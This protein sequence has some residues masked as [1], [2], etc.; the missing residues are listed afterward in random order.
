M[1]FLP[2]ASANEG[3]SNGVDERVRR[4][5][6]HVFELL[7]FRPVI[8]NSHCASRNSKTYPVPVA[9]RSRLSEPNTISRRQALGG[10][11]ALGGLG[12]LR[13]WGRPL[14]ASDKADIAFI[15]IGGYGA[16]NMVGLAGDNIVAVCDVDWRD[17]DQLPGRFTRASEVAMQYPGAKR[18]D[19]WRVM[20]D[21][22]EKQIDAV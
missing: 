9:G 18:F 2:S 16:Q 10:A 4:L 5:D 6:G 8:C 20:L 12:A 19:D 1:L 3:T 11:A 15:G 22:M 7:P 17:K 21:R 14:G 13:A